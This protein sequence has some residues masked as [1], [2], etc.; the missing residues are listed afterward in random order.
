MESICPYS[1]QRV[2]GPAALAIGGVGATSEYIV[3]RSP[4]KLPR[5]WVHTAQGSDRA[6]SFVFVLRWRMMWLRKRA[7]QLEQYASPL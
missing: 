6:Q 7:E 3:A 4:L 5:I 2:S 1:A